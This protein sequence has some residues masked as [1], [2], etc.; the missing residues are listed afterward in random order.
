MTTTTSTSSRTPITKQWVTQNSESMLD[1]I[2][3]MVRVM[4][5]S[6][7]VPR[8]NALLGL[9]GSIE[10]G[11]LTFQCALKSY[12]QREIDLNRDVTV[13]RDMHLC[14]Q[15]RIDEIQRQRQAFLALPWYLRVWRALKKEL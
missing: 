4:S 1:V 14:M 11:Q 8:R 12:I 2:D 13:A 6:R 5:P 3:S 10:D 15:V 9:L 7:S